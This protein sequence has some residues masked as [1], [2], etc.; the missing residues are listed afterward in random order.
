MVLTLMP[1]PERVSM[2]IVGPNK[3]GRRTLS[4][5]E[6]AQREKVFDY[7]KGVYR[8][9][10]PNDHALTTNPFSWIAQL[11]ENPLVLAT[12][13]ENGTHYDPILGREVK[14]TK[15]QKKLNANGVPYYE[16]LGGRSML[17]KDALSVF[18]NMTIDN[19]GINKYDFFDSDGIDKSVP[20][21]VAKTIVS[22]L[23]ML[24][25]LAP[26]YSGALVLRELFKAAPMLYGIGSA[27]FTDNAELPMLNNLAGVA[28]R[29]STSTSDYAKDHMFSFENFGNLVSDV[30][31]QWG[32]QKWIVK[33]FQKLSKNSEAVID[34]AKG[35]ALN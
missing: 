17:G 21:T 23:P 35:K 32:Q 24:T 2:G 10:T 12:Y 5:R 1:N 28:N 9:Y 34:A 19:K 30:A 20:G 15:G 26:Y 8:D 29:F 27:L 33:S 14:H 11:W 3:V 31:L 16:T 6:I 18:D 25:P 22:F 7:E 13:D 4:D